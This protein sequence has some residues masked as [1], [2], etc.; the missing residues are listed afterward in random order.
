MNLKQVTICALIVELILAAVLLRVCHAET[1]TD[2]QAVKC[3]LGEAR[4]ENYAS[5]LGH[6]EAI[7]NRGTL[8]GVYGCRADLSREWPYIVRT[9]IDKQARQA[10]QESKY[11]NTVDGADHWGSVVVDKAWIKTMIKAGYVK[12]KTI[13][14]TVFYRE[15]K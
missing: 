12:T 5:L 14:N 9:G 6:A 10:W 11:S 8:S 1:I 2:E 3:L 13:K 4:G 15:D 7:R